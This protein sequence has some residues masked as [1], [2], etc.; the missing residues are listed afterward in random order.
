M[1]YCCDAAF[2]Q[3]TVYPVYI[4]VLTFCYYQLAQR[5]SVQWKDYLL[6]L[7]L[8]GYGFWAF[9]LNHFVSLF[10]LGALALWYH[11]PVVPHYWRLRKFPLLKSCLIA[12][13]WSMT[14][15][16]LPMYLQF[17]TVDAQ[18]ILLGMERFLFIFVA[19]LQSDVV[20]LEVDQQ[21]GTRTLPMILGSRWTRM[22]SIFLLGILLLL[23]SYFAFEFLIS[24]ELVFA[25]VITYL[26]FL[27][28]MLLAKNRQKIWIDSLILLLGLLQ[29]VFWVL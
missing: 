7:L 21:Q 4:G 3:F 14:T 25:Q 8:I 20:D 10:I 9:P 16:V 6:L 13:I 23:Q 15:L 22:V 24:L 19:S 17:Q 11:S 5:I 2:D 27:T 28:Y 26:I 18:L 1:H 12:G 29:V